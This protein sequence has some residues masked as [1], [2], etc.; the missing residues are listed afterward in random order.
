MSGR[1]RGRLSDIYGKGWN[2]VFLEDRGFKEDGSWVEL[3]RKMGAVGDDLDLFLED[4][5]SSVPS[6]Q[7]QEVQEFCQS[8]HLNDL[9]SELRIA[10]RRRGAWLD[11]RSSEGSRKHTNPPNSNALYRLL[12]LPVCCPPGLHL[13]GISRLMQLMAAL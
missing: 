8:V 6:C 7:V 1:R 9:Q 11:D 13:L 4:F 10:Y 3:K 5:E 12:K 2:P